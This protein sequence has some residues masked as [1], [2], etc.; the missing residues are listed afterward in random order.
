[1]PAAPTR[2]VTPKTARWR[3]IVAVLV[4]AAGV[5]TLAVGPSNMAAAIGFYSLG[6]ATNSDPGFLP[7]SQ[8]VEVIS[9]NVGLTSLTHVQVNSPIH[10]VGGMSPSNTVLLVFDY[11]TLDPLTLQQLGKPALVL[12]S[13]GTKA[14]IGS[15]GGTVHLWGVIHKLCASSATLTGLIPGIGTI[16]GPLLP[17]TGCVPLAPLLPTLQPIINSGVLKGRTLDVNDLDIDV[18]ALDV[19]PGSSNESVTLPTGQ[20]KVTDG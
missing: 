2:H 12:D 20:L 19:V 14:T 5:M 1:M 13:Q 9:P 3:R 16:L 8:P 10:V 6:T 17:P 11:V 4:G 18:Y 15:S 7:E